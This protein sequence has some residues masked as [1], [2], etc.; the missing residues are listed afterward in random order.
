MAANHS[1]VRAGKGAPLA[2]TLNPK[3]VLKNFAV[4]LSAQIGLGETTI[5]NYLS[6]MRRIFP[7]LGM[8]PTARAVDKYVAAMRSKGLSQSH[9]VNT[10]IALERY[11]LFMHIRIKLGRPKQ[12]YKEVQGTLSEAEMARFIGAAH[13]LRE[14]AILALLAY[15]GLRNKELCGLRICDLDRIGQVLH[16][17]GTKT[18]RD[19]TVMIAGAC[20]ALLADYLSQRGGGPNDFMFVTVRNGHQMQQQ[21]LRKMVR[22]VAKRAGI[23][24]RVYPHLIRHSLATNLLDRGTGLLAIKEQLGHVYISTTMRY[25]HSAPARLQEEYRMHAPSYL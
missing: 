16:A 4:Y 6:V 13:T 7:A 9:V 25:I 1:I 17:H 24:K 2:R 12:P 5:G 20:L 3:T 11:G 23:T 15:S 14:R 22:T 10:S 8:R 18:Q 21:D 19:R